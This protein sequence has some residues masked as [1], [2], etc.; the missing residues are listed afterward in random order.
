MFVVKL[1]RWKYGLEL[2]LIKKM[3]CLF[4]STLENKWT[5]ENKFNTVKKILKEECLVSLASFS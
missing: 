1:Y 3:L 2:R 4:E 5:H